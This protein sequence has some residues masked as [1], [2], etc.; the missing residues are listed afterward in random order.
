MNSLY[1]EM[2]IIAKKGKIL[3]TE[4]L[5]LLIAGEKQYNIERQILLNFTII[6]RIF[7]SSFS[8]FLPFYIPLEIQCPFPCF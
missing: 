7:V 1:V 6:L 5:S 4:I 8:T 2:L 3:V